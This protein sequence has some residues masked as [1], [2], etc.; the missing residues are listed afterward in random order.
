MTALLDPTLLVYVGG[1]IQR[2]GDDF[3]ITSVGEIYFR[4]R[5]PA[6]GEE[7]QMVYG[8][9]EWIVKLSPLY[10]DGDTVVFNHSEEAA[11]AIRQIVAAVQAGKEPAA[12]TTAV[13]PLNLDALKPNYYGDYRLPA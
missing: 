12:P 10:G 13:T 5:R 4:R 6:E 7:I 9:G 3:A 2:C 8:H 1:R 11:K